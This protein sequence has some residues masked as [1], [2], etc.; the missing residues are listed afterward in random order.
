MF[1]F[2]EQKLI[3]IIPSVDSLRSRRMTAQ[4]T[5]R[6]HDTSFGQETSLVQTLCSR[7]S[8]DLFSVALHLQLPIILS[9]GSLNIQVFCL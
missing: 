2:F 5:D 1:A 9:P 6:H 3:I 8:K 7:P 4:A